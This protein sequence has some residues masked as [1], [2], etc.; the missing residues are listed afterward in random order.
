M[1][2]GGGEQHKRWG[3]GSEGEAEAGDSEVGSHRRCL[4]YFTF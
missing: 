1:E 2:G 4:G 3:G